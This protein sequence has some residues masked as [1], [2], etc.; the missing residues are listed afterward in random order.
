MLRR[1]KIK[2]HEIILG[3]QQFFHQLSYR[4]LHWPENSR[5]HYPEI[6]DWDFSEESG[7]YDIPSYVAFWLNPLYHMTFENHREFI[8]HI[9]GATGERYE[10]EWRESQGFVMAIRRHIRY[11]WEYYNPEN[12]MNPKHEVYR[13]FSTLEWEAQLRAWESEQRAKRNGQVTR[14]VSNSLR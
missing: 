6:L 12:K 1:R 3:Q 4:F 5:W 13:Y 11:E 9:N 2:A 10:Y 8:N 7:Y 14:E